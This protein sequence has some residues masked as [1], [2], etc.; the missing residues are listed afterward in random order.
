MIIRMRIEHDRKHDY[1]HAPN[2]PNETDNP[3]DPADPKRQSGPDNG[4]Y[5]AA[6]NDEDAADE[7]ENEGCRRLLAGQLLRQ[8]MSD[9]DI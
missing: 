1:E 8:K 2:H 7:R 4:D 9:F 3:S 6:N 5:Q